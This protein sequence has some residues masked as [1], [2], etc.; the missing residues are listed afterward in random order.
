[1]EGFRRRGIG[2]RLHAVNVTYPS[3]WPVEHPDR[4]QLY[5]LATPNGQK[6]GIA[7]EE[8]GLPYEAHRVDI[9]K[10]DQFDP[11]YVGINPNSKIP[12]IV[13]PDGPD[14]EPIVIFESGAILIT[15]PTR[16]AS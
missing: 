4:I 9:M 3:R 8:L 1:M 6:I 5:S 11:E 10:D 16:P 15:W 12:T 7:L 14:G 2:S 13:D